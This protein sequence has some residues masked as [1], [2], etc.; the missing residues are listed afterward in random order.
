MLEFLGRADQQ[1]KV[2]GFRV[3]PGE[4]ESSLVR[5]PAVAEAA[6]VASPGASGLTQLVAYVI[7][8]GDEPPAAQD[9][10][11][12]LR[13]TLPDYMVPSQFIFM[14]EL[15]LTGSGKVDRL[16]LPEPNHSRPDLEQ[17]FVAPRSD[18]EEQVAA[19]WGEVL[20]VR[21]PGVYDN[22]FE[23]GGHSLLATQM[24]SRLREHFGIEIPVRRLFQGPT[25][26]DLALVVVQ[27]R[28]EQSNDEEIA[29]FLRELEGLSGDDGEAQLCRPTPPADEA[30]GN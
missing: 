17:S 10:R 2:R 25:I 1:L 9:L 4:V 27:T 14:D 28:V 29:A 5:H 6:V 11:A 19:L 16:R 22:F 12:F 26:A 21:E 30:V 18:L 15:P 24:V 13:E 8:A 23:L 3:E 20:G 7:A